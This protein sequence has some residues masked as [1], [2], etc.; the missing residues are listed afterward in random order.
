MQK[1]QTSTN[2]WLS[3]TFQLSAKLTWVYSLG[4]FGCW[5]CINKVTI[6]NST[7]RTANHPQLRKVILVLY[8]FSGHG[9]SKKQLQAVQRKSRFH[10]LLQ[11]I[12]VT[13]QGNSLQGPNAL[14]CEVKRLGSRAEAG[15]TPRS[16][17]SEIRSKSHLRSGPRGRMLGNPGHRHSGRSPPCSCTAHWCRGAGAG[18]RRYLGIREGTGAAEVMLSKHF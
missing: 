7:P 5:S 16:P 6:Q 4:T 17:D 11:I 2:V 8:S 1:A 13:T 10:F 12:C 18:T 9:S 15:L 3:K 14:G